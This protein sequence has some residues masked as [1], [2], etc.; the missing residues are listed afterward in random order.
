MEPYIN[1]KTGVFDSPGYLDIT[2]A[3]LDHLASMNIP[4]FGKSVIDVGCGTGRLTEFLIGQGANV[5]GVDG[6]EDN[7]QQM[8]LFYPDVKAEAVDLETDDLLNYGP[9]DIV[10]CYG[11]LYHLSD[12]L[13]FIRNAEKLCS[14]M[15]LIETCVTDALEPLCK[16]EIEDGTNNSQS[17][18]HAGSRPSPAYVIFCLKKAGF[19]FIYTPL[20]KPAH[21]EFLYEKQYNYTSYKNGRHIREI[22]IA[23]RNPM[24]NDRLV[25][26][27]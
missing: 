12:P 13:H 8:H 11:I 4:L 26:V 5:F 15:I 24:N 20:E 2:K 21:P 17:I 10:F 9:F 6:R 7:I 25:L 19:P 22:F 1:A 16:I 18:H 3:R 14:D 27:G 23:S